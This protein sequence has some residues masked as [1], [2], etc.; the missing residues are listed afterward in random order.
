[1]TDPRIHAYTELYVLTLSILLENYLQACRRIVYGQK[2]E[3][4]T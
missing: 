2:P 4:T 3:V 1:M